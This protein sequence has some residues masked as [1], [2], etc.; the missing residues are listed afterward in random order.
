MKKYVLLILFAFSFSHV[1]NPAIVYEGNAGDYPIRVVV[2]PPGVVPGLAEIFVQSLDHQVT[3]VKTQ[4]MK[5]DAGVNGSPPADFAKQMFEQPDK[6]NAEL[7]LM[8]FG[9]YSINV[10]VNGSKGIANAVVPVLSIATKRVEMDWMMKS[11]LILLMSILVAGFVTIVGASISESTLDPGKIPDKLRRRKATYFMG[12]TFLF[13]ISV[14]F[15]GKKWWNSIADIYYSNIF[16]PMDTEL[17][18]NSVENSY[19]VSIEITD[20]LWKSGRYAPFV[21]DHGKLIHSYFIN[22][23]LSTFGHVHPIMNKLNTDKFDLLLPENLEQ[24]LYYVY[25]DVT[26]ET[27]FSQT[28]LDTVEIFTSQIPSI[29]EIPSV[30]PD[31]SWSKINPNNSYFNSEFVFEDNSKMVW[32]NY[33]NEIESGFIAFNFKLIDEQN[34]P[35]PLEPYIDM[36]GHGIIYKKD[37]TQFIHI[38]PT[39]NFSMASQEVLYELKEGVEINPQELFCTF[40]FR[41]EEGKLV[42]NI[43]SDGQVTFPPFEF[44][45]PGEYRIWIQVKSNGIVKTAVFDLNINSPNV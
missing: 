5:W 43:N 23:N 32:D 41:N 26:H 40:G 7:W 16:K 24:G 27:G 42:K 29:Q 15:G 44:R 6:F 25:S 9:S 1:G 39:G 33:L 31:N 12:F 21:P 28:L 37:G 18:L 45:E 22:K 2:R 11:I 4:P 20:P 14:L 30:D 19:I 36:G 3:E 13:C 38:H 17:K 8:D 34:T 35:L 10:E